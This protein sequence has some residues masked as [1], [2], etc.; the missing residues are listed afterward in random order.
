MVHCKVVDQSGM[1]WE[2]YF[3]QLKNLRV[4]NNYLVQ[5]VKIRYGNEI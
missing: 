1:G 5:C 3:E 4:G 2:T